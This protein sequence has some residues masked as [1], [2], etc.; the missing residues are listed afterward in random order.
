MSDTRTNGSRGAPGSAN[1]HRRRSRRTT[2]PAG[3]TCASCPVLSQRNERAVRAHLVTMTAPADH[4]DEEARE[5]DPECKEV[6]RGA[7]PP[8]LRAHAESMINLHLQDK[9]AGDRRGH[10][11]PARQRTA[12]Q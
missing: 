5:M 6:A 9:P 7:A 8:G 2:A 4:A 11:Q 3:T 1:R 12:G 10:H